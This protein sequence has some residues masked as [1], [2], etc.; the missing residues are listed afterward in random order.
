LQSVKRGVT[1]EKGGKIKPLGPLE[2]NQ[3]TGDTQ[4]V[5][6]TF[7]KLNGLTQHGFKVREKGG[8][9]IDEGIRGAAE[10]KQNDAIGGRAVCHPL[11]QP[12]LGGVY[13]EIRIQTGKRWQTAKH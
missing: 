6:K 8:G 12:E 3:K 1:I 9:I 11:A 7:P 2:C 4:L 10:Q 5:K 13:R